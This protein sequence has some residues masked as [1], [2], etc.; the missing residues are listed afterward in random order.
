MPLKREIGTFS[1]VALVVGQVVGV[2]I[3]L[4]PAGMARSVGSPV[5]LLVIWLAIGAMTLSGALCYGELAAR[6]PEAGGSYVYLREAYGRGAAFLYG[7][8]VLLVLDPGLTAVFGVGAAAYARVLFPQSPVGEQMLAIAA[9]ITIGSITILGVRLGTRIL[10]ILT[11]VKVATLFFIIVYGFAGGFGDYQNFKPFFVTPADA[12]GALAGGLVGAFFAFA[13][14]WEVTRIAGEIRDAERNAPRALVIGVVVLTVLY[15]L[16]SAVFLYLVPLASITSD[17]TFAAQAGEAL[18][19]SLGG[20]LFS[21]VVVTSVIGTLFA[22]FIAS[23]RVY[24]AMANDRLFFSSFGDL[25]P[26]FGTPHRATL[27]QMAIAC[28]LVLSGSFN[29]IISYFFFVVV[30]FVALTVVGLFRIRKRPFSGYR[31]PIF[32][33]TPLFFLAITAVVLF[34]IAMKNPKQ[35]VVGAAVVLLGVPVYYLI[36]RSKPLQTQDDGMDQDNTVR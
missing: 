18:F 25:H 21:L 7:W 1:A 35:T 19:G 29:E 17:E 31:T 33:L 8:M 10:G 5:W 26:Q 12:F 24:Y 9:I 30:L 36:F 34:F 27:V 2:G 15:L 11:V 28:I 13:G 16:T 32:P 23:P 20:R 22:Y 4:T 3:F 14:W 6:F